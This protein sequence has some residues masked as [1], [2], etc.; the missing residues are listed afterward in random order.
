MKL[1]LIA[2][3]VA[4]MAAAGS[5]NAVFDAGTGDFNGNSELFLFAVDGTANIQGFFDLGVNIT[6]FT[7]ANKGIGT[8]NSWNLAANMTSGLGGVTGSW[9]EA[10]NTFVTASKPGNTQWMVGAY[11][12]DAIGRGIATSNTPTNIVQ[13]QQDFLLQNFQAAEP[14]FGANTRLGNHSAVANGANTALAS[15]NPAGVLGASF[16]P[17]WNGNFVGIAFENLGTAQNVYDMQANFLGG[18]ADVTKFAGQFNL[19]P[20][21]VLSYPA[22]VPEPE[23]YALMLAGLGMLGMIVRRRRPR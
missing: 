23:T 4:G 5:A 11:E 8:N 2:L 19:N 16:A 3:A 15:S 12:F 10:W 9:S 17:S 18:S 1:K 14:T 6:D 13:E 21:G 22:P 7:A 20:A